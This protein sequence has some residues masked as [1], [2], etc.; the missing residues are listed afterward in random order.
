MNAL[1]KLNQAYESLFLPSQRTIYLGIFRVYVAFHITKKLLVQWPFLDVLYGKGSFV[2]WSPKIYDLIPTEIVH[3]H[4]LVICCAYLALAVMMAFGIGRRYTVALVFACEELLNGTDG[5]V[6]DGG[7]NLLKFGLL[8]LIAANSFE[9]LSISKV[10][11]QRAW[12]MRLDNF[13]TN[14]AVGC[15]VGHLLMAYFL[16]GSGKL[17]ADVWY[18]GTAV[19]Y[20][21]LLERFKGTSYNE[22]I[23]QNAYLVTLGTYSVMLWE[24]F[25]PVLIFN[26]RLRLPLLAF[27]VMMH[28]GIYIFMMINAFEIYFIANYGFFFT[29]AELISFKEWI[30]ARWKRLFAKRSAVPL[31]VASAQE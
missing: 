9:V 27:G 28:L 8:Y 16:S 5:F 25:F 4:Y 22:L 31:P 26:K 20:T 6:L 21:M 2:H 14:V 12:Q 19:Y 13:C 30:V 7:D 17:H 23:V 11:Y 15:I 29:N 3:N 18:H 1:A 24:M 10:H